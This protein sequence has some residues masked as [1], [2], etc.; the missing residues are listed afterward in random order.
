M[1]RKGKVN[2][3]APYLWLEEPRLYPK[4][5]G[6]HHQLPRPHHTELLQQIV[7]ERGKTELIGGATRHSQRRARRGLGGANHLAP[8]VGGS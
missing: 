5:R 1:V 3:G 8:P 4:A 7:R 2:P 6:L